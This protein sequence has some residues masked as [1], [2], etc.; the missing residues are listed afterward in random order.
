ML[1]RVG[2]GSMAF[3]MESNMTLGLSQWAFGTSQ[4]RQLEYGQQTWGGLR[5]H[6]KM[7]D[8]A[9]RKSN[10]LEPPQEAK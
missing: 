3:V 10:L 8:N 9:L 5:S 4:K 7:P 2:E 1:E 6:F